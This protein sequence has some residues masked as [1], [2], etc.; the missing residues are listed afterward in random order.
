MYAQ[1]SPLGVL[2]DVISTGANDV[3]DIEMTDGR[4]LLLPAIRE[5]ILE[6]D[7]E[8]ARMRVHILDGLLDDE[9]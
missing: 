3:Y 9:N 7:V 8:N 6:V 5:C 1:T 2:K 4:Q